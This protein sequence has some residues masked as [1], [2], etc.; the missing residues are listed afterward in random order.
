M[1]SLKLSMI[2]VLYLSSSLF[3]FTGGA[4]AYPTNFSS[5]FSNT[6]FTGNNSTYQTNH[7]RILSSLPSNANSSNGFYNATSLWH[8]TRPKEK[9]RIS[10]SII[11]TI[12]LPVTVAVVLFIIIDCCF[13]TRRKRK[14]FNSIHAEIAVN[15]ITT[16]E[17]LQF[18]FGT[19]QA[20]TN[21]FS[22]NNKLSEGGFGEVYKV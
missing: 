11:I 19:I 14:K 20:A 15:E 7:N 8:V 4:S 22:I 3:S 10:S 17:S 2:L 5:R 12:V 6:N 13:L 9:K 21:G 1:Y 18:G 16:V